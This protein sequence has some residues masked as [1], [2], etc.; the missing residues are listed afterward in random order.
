V[1]QQGKLAAPLGGATSLVPRTGRDK[2]VNHQAVVVGVGVGVGGWLL[3]GSR[4]K[5]KADAAQNEQGARARVP[6]QHR[7]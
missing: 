3:F 4:E 2:P 5:N 6:P 7:T 1:G